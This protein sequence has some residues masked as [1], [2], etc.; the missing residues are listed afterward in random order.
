MNN[1]GGQIASGLQ[2]TA[3]GAALG[4]TVGTSPMP[5]AARD[6]S[7][8]GTPLAELVDFSAAS[9][10]GAE[11]LAQS[12]EE[13]ELEEQIDD[14]VYGD[15]SD[16]DEDASGDFVGEIDLWDTSESDYDELEDM[17]GDD[18]ADDDVL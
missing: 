16:P 13:G 18:D 11:S 8:D 10:D 5:D 4:I 9:R 2:A 7:Q 1:L 14:P 17:T 12:F 3:I 15:H 6:L